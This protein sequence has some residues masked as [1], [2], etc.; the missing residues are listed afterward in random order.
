MGLE[1]Y[2]ETLENEAFDATSED[3]RVNLDIRFL[4]PRT[5]VGRTI[6]AIAMLVEQRHQIGR[7]HG[8]LKDSNVLLTA[9]GPTLID[10][11]DLHPGDIAPGWTPDWSSPE[12]VL[13]NPV[14]PT[15][16][17]YPLGIMLLRLLGGRLMGEV[18]KFRTAP[19]LDGRDEFDIFYDPS[20]HIES[21]G[22]MISPAGR[23]EWLKFVRTCLAFDPEIRTESAAKFVTEL[24]S[25]LNEYPL[26]GDVAVTIPGELV[27]ARLP[28]GDQRVIRVL[29]E[30]YPGTPVEGSRFAP[31]PRRDTQVR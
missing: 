8:D 13:G 10:E 4:V 7:I 5:S 3:G 15:A 11:F 20:V 19:L 9:N 24:G 23:R 26:L 1:N 6:L 28:D 17:I 2:L 29:R 18:R 25:L 21:D 12:Q 22:S 14:T 31:V 30:A 27:V 16:D